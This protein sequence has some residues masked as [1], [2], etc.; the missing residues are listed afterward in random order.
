MFRSDDF[1]MLAFELGTDVA[2]PRPVSERLRPAK[3]L[4]ERSAMY[5]RFV[6]A[7]PVT[8]MHRVEDAQAMTCGFAGADRRRD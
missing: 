4:F 5:S 3:P 2:T 6:G 8:M 7:G 1:A